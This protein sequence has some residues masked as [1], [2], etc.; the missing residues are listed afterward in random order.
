M[1]T[2]IRLVAA[3]AVICMLITLGAFLVSYYFVGNLAL[4]SHL[5]VLVAVEALAFVPEL[6]NDSQSFFG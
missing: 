1:K 5:Q 6:F 3:V 4:A 2:F